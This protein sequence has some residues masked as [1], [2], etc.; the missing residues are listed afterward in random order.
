MT[1]RLHATCI[2]LAGRGV[3]LCG[4]PGSGKSDLALRM[5]DRGALLVADDI[6]VVAADAGRLIGRAPEGFAGL[7]EMRGVGIVARPHTAAAPIVLVV[8]L[9]APVDR[10]PDGPVMRAISGIVLPHFAL[11]GLEPSAPLKLEALVS[12]TA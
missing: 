12:L 10:L 4:A 1:L 3:L 7:I 5:I 9:D 6:T 2:A 8:Q 11:A